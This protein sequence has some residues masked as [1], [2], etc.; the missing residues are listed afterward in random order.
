MLFQP[1]NC[2]V[3]KKTLQLIKDSY[4]NNILIESDINEYD[5]KYQFIIYKRID[6]Y[7][8]SIFSSPYFF[9]SYEEA[10]KYGHKTC[11]AIINQI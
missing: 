9:D 5:S 8:S 6:N 11:N 10:I 4:P 1:S 3:N 7:C 2:R